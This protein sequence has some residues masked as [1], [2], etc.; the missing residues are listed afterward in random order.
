MKGI[1]KAKWLILLAWIAAVAVL[2]V[3]APNM[4]ELVREKGQIKIADGYSSTIAEQ[5][6]Q[7]INE[8]SGEG[9]GTSLALVFHNEN[10]LT[11]ADL[12]E[13]KQAIDQLKGQQEELGITE[14][15][16]HFDQEELE[17]QLLSQ[18]GKTI[19]VSLS[20]EWNNRT[21]QELSEDLHAAIEN[22]ELEHYYTGS[23]LITE[24]VVLTTEAGVKKTEA[25]TV[26]F[27]L[28]VLIAVFRSVVAP[29]IPLITVGISYLASQSIV[30]FL[31]DYVDFPL[32]NFTQIF[33]VAVLFGIGTD[34]S[35]L[36]MN[37][38]KEELLEQDDLTSAIAVTY[39]TAGKTVLF[40]G[41]AVLI[42]FS[43]LGFSQFNIYQSAVAVAVGIAVLLIALFTIF[44]FFMAVL[45]A[46]I[47]WPAKGSMQHKPS[48]LWHAAGRFAFSRPAIALIIVAVA[49]IPFVVTYNHQVSYN[50]VNEIGEG[51]SS[52]RGYEIIEE[53]FGPGEALSTRIVLKNDEEMDQ[54]EYLTLM[55]KISEELDQ[56]DGVDKVRSLTRPAGEILEDLQIASQAETLKDGIN[57]GNEGIK[58]IRDGL[59][60]AQSRLT[61]SA[62]EL[63]KAADGIAS[64]VSGTSELKSG[65]SELQNGL[66]QIEAG[67]RSGS[68]G[69]GEA[70][71]G[72]EEIKKNAEK[73]LAGY[74]QL[75]SGYAEIKENLVT[76]NT[77]YA[78]IE[79]GLTALNSQ[80]AELEQAFAYLDNYLKSQS[81]SQEQQ[82]ALQ[83]FKGIQAYFSAL[84]QNL[85]TLSNSLTEL[86]AGL[87]SII[88]GMNTAGD[89]FATLNNGQDQLIAGMQQ[90]IDGIGK[91]QQGL[92]AAADAQGTV[93]G[94]LPQVTD[95]LGA[96]QNGQQQLLTG[97]ADIEDQLNQLTDGLGQGVDGLTQIHDGL[98]EAEGYLTEL[99]DPDR[100]SDVYIPEEILDNEEYETVLD[101]YL[102]PDRKIAT[103][104]VILSKNPY[105]IEALDIMDEIRAAVERAVQDTKLENAELAIGG[106]TSQFHD[107]RTISDHDFNRTLI[108][109][110]IGIGLILM[111]QFKSLIMPIYLV[112]SLFMTYFTAMGITEFIFVDWLNYEG[113]NWAVPFFAFVL[114]MALGV[115]YSIFLMGRF[116]EYRGEPIEPSMIKSMSNMGTVIISAVVILG[117]TFAAMMPSGV[118]SLLQI[119]TI[120]IIG[121]ILYSIIFLPLFVPVMVKIFDK[122][123]WWPFMQNDRKQ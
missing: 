15:L 58:E 31:V 112:A 35:I 25:I 16:T 77:N 43:V 18:D 102:S 26:V 101:T 55:E 61:A 103:I 32:S 9:D 11:D 84:Q 118:Q 95:G 51:Y 67:V 82:M 14:I 97:F 68:M 114:L 62:P 80:L 75:A 98:S 6:I 24:D 17:D 33:L 23:A 1:L 104:D 69:A 88:Q 119:S 28:V 57:E 38:F 3:T 64:L 7:E 13:A 36:L 89:N 100:Q 109:I 4:A 122:A 63:G 108:F 5:F 91:L 117:G 12:A 121:L 79:E 44:P 10:G 99:A 87:G 83:S 27:I 66:R 19:L 123:N 65:L 30:A 115:D 107:L 21:A 47:F 73:L 34:Y 39:K 52:V 81:A 86:N 20:V 113:I 22:I 48:K 59:A 46:K 110:L 106:V 60:D 105:S 8:Q 53:S 78:Q 90:L 111:I 76:L 74:E 56:V 42:G 54:I 85:P 92:A 41:I 40:S 50:S 116:N 120:V 45:G 49:T 29:F 70:Q 96:I 72:L 94:K 2:L 37:R 71:A 93:I